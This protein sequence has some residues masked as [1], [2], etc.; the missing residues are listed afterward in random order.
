MT[1]NRRE[2]VAASSLGLLGALAPRGLFAQAPAGQAAPPV[3][4]AF[5]DVRRNVG[6][7]TAR[8]GTIGYLSTPGGVVVIDA[9]A[10][11]VAAAFPT[12]ASR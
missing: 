5:A 2:F 1:F 6:L 3:V 10:I 7:F 12:I 11:V 4:P 8:G 9:A